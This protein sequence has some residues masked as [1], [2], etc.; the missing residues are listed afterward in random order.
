MHNRKNHMNACA[1]K[2]IY[3]YIWEEGSVG[4]IF[5]PPTTTF[6]KLREALQAAVK[7][8]AMLDPGQKRA[9]TCTTHAILFAP[10]FEEYRHYS[11]E[12]LAPTS[13]RTTDPTSL[14]ALPKKSPCIKSCL[15]ML[16]RQPRVFASGDSRPTEDT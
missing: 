3:I 13:S 4:V 9:S 12:C 14:P 15:I 11:S 6:E 5:I 1:L 8:S 10:K 16:T 2:D 7:D